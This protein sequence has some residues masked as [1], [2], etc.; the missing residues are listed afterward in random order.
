MLLRA[1]LEFYCNHRTPI[2]DYASLASLEECYHRSHY[3][4][5]KETRYSLMIISLKYRFELVRNIYPTDKARI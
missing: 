3:V 1:A 4:I 5:L 2:F